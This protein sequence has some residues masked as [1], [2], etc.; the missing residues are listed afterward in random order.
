MFFDNTSNRL[1]TA[2]VYKK[3]TAKKGRY[4]GWAYGFEFQL[5]MEVK[6]WGKSCGFDIETGE[7]VYESELLNVKSSKK[8]GVKKV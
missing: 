7:K 5:E 6:N 3:P 8:I 2:E 4:T 1:Y